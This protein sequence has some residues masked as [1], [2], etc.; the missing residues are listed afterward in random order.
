MF[1][2]F[3][4]TLRVQRHTDRL[5]HYGRALQVS[6][7]WDPARHVQ[8]PGAGQDAQGCERRHQ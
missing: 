7:F 1:Y 2:Y 5:V 4:G 6:R 8:E 3:S